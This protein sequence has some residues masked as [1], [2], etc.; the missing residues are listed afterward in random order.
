[1]IIKFSVDGKT[2]SSQK[3]YT[4]LQAL[5]Y[6]NIDIPHLCSYKINSTNTFEK[7]NNILRCKL[8]LVKVKKKNENS[9]SYKYACD[10][11]VEIGVSV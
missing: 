5:S 11:I 10:E 3:G 1:M 4:I 6:I 2:V 9:Y 8:C 7:K